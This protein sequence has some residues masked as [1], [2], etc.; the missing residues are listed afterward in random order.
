MPL[1]TLHDLLVRE[2]RD[3][4]NA[5]QQ[6]LDALPLLAQATHNP[7]LKRLLERHHEETRRQLERLARLFDA[8]GASPAGKT[9]RGVKGLLEEALETAGEEGEPR[10][11]DAAIIVAA[12]KVGHYEIAAYGTA[13]TFARRLGYT[14]AARLLDQTLREESATDEKLARAAESRV[15]AMAAQ[16]AEATA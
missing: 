9:S 5:E 12:Q 4:N 14:E 7:E 3:L 2:L 16:A 6:V 13:R 15:T 10:V 11:L 8:L 1:D